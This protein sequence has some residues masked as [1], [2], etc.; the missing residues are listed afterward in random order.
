MLAGAVLAV[1][2]CSGPSPSPDAESESPGPVT[3]SPLA[4]P[5]P[6]PGQQPRA[7]SPFGLPPP[8]PSLSFTTSAEAEQHPAGTVTVAVDERRLNIGERVISLLVT[9]DTSAPLS[10]SAA[11]LTTPLYSEASIW[12]PGPT[13]S[14]TVNPG[15][16]V[17]LPAPLP[18]PHCD[19]LSSSASVALT[20]DG[21]RRELDAADPHSVLA[22]LHRQDCLELAV[23][24]VAA[25]DLLPELT[26]A[27]DRRTAVVHVMV[28]PSGG[29]GT[30]LLEGFGNTT[31]LTE[32][33]QRPWPRD[34]S[35]SGSDSP[36]TLD[37]AVAPARCDPHALAEDK[38]GTKLPMDVST[39]GRSGQ[40][41]LEPSPEFTRSVYAFVAGA[42]GR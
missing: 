32:D 38:T 8:Q 37:I 7:S 16:T 4:L 27:P 12:T 14:S 20:V 5:S 35:I 9:N 23:R 2:A 29:G 41:R 13:G 15:A 33:R 17:A 42:C 31:L 40:L 10:V 36:A 6:S 19:S 18:G 1:A 28:S 24:E 25:L 11:M 34:I 26:I 3:T 39:E 30:V 22:R 21:S